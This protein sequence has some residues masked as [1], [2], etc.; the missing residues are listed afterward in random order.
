MQSWPRSPGKGL[1]A[2]PRLGTL[3][4][5]CLAPSSGTPKATGA[6]GGSARLALDGPPQKRCEEEAFWGLAVA[7]GAMD[8]AYLGAVSSQD[9]TREF[10]R[11]CAACY[12]SQIKSYFVGNVM[13][14]HL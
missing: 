1:K 8:C 13:S 2:G 12:Y 6:S 7:E 14:S 4:P 11:T 5:P 9:R 3:G 10:P